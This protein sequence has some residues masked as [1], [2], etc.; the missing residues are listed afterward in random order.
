[1]PGPTNDP[2]LS[3]KAI[4]VLSTRSSVR[5]SAWSSMTGYID[6]TPALTL[7]ATVDE[8]LNEE[9]DD[10]LFESIFV[11]GIRSNRYYVV[12]L[13]VY[14][15]PGMADG[16]VPRFPIEVLTCGLIS[17]AEDVKPLTRLGDELE[18]KSRRRN[19]GEWHHP[20]R[21]SQWGY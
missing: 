18:V 21:H 7:N 16:A 6:R 4:T 5:T 3:W 20:V 11:Q 12:P 10:P 13:H 19:S 17:R 2:V 9:L 14:W 15:K 1:M 8:Q